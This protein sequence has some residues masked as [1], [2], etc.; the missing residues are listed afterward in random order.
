LT[1]GLT[2]MLP[3]FEFLHAV[4]GQGCMIGIELGPPSSL[5]LK[6]AWSVVHKM[7]RSL[8]PQALVIPLLDDHG[9]MTQVAGHHLD[10]I[11]LLPPLNLSMDDADHF[12]S[13]FETVLTGLEQFPGPVWDLLTRI[14]K[15]SLTDR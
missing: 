10:V 9:I 13:A 14:G 1:A 5:A 7:G 6:T 8:F 2:E 15:F 4:R 3:R 11:K 12:L